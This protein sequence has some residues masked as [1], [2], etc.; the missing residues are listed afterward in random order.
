MRHFFLIFLPVLL[1]GKAYTQPAD[2]L[3]QPSTPPE[4][5][6]THSQVSLKV[7]DMQGQ[8]WKDMPLW[9][10]NPEQPGVVYQA[11]TNSRGQAYFLLP[12]GAS[13]QVNAKDQPAFG[14]VKTLNDGY[15][16]SRYT[17]FYTPKTYSET[18]RGDT[19]FQ[20]V[21][22]TQQPIRSRILL[23]L[24][25]KNFEEQPLP[26]EDIYFNYQ[27]S[28]KVFA[29]TTGADGQAL[30]MLPRGDSIQ[31]STAF[32][33]NVSGFELP[34]DDRL[35][36]LRLT[37]QTIGKEAFLKREA[38]RARLAARRDSLY[39]L[40]RARDSIAAA[41]DSLRL[42]SGDYDYLFL[43]N[44]G[45][46]MKQILEKVGE[47]AAAEQEQLS[48]NEQLYELTGES[49]KSAF[50]RNRAG[51]S[52]NV[53]V[54]DLTG[55]M[56]PY[57]DEVL[58]WHALAV[59]PGAQNRYLFFN[60][61]DRKPE[62]PIGATGGFYTT[63]IP[64]MPAL[65]QTMQSTTNGGSG[66]E[67]EENDIEALLEAMRMMGE[68]DELVL[69]ADNYSDVRDMELL[70]QLRTPVRIVLAGNLDHGINEDYLQIAWATGGSIHTL[71][72][73]IET[74][75]TVNEGQLITIGSHR[76]RMSGGIFVKE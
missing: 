16:R 68:G 51:W 10:I 64:D 35:G 12:K 25:V 66:G 34:D 54:T 47:Q 8:S 38:E 70:P 15:V 40:A 67:S 53:I 57:M 58:L 29:V 42:L 23:R 44:S 39:E 72:E 31:L 74:L 63:E 60:D 61:G 52:S 33:P 5:T 55:S 4:A 21:P 2:T 32:V 62:K 7:T 3:I 45:V 27:N 59:V 24:L 71:T 56:H 18:E 28:G 75:K 17:L 22:P 76:Y 1:M 49:V 65:L 48:E 41:R 11:V 37:L 36:T 43:M 46:N 73:D 9:L 6:A 69:I 30:L 26:D 19:V 13:Y 50:Y 20:E 14:E